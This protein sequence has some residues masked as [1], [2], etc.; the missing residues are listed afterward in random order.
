MAKPYVA[1]LANHCYTELYIN[2]PLAFV[3]ASI[4]MCPKL[5]TFL[6]ILFFF[7]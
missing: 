1:L 7:F 2:H 3:V 4:C 5:H 6:S